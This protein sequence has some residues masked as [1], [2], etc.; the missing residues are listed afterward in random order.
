MIAAAC[1]PVPVRKASRPKTGYWSGSGTRVDLGDE[2]HVLAE[3]R[4]VVVDPPHQLE[5]DHQQVDRRVADALA[6]AAAEPC[7]RSAPASSAAMEL[8]H[9]EAAVAVAVPVDFHR[10]D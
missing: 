1:T 3:L 10:R 6:D 4:Q 8:M 9:A 7:T 2:A 5:V